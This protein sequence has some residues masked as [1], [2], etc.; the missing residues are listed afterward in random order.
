V[1]QHPGATNIPWIRQDEATLLVQRAERAAFVSDGRT[2]H[3][4]IHYIHHQ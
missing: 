2:L 1:L 4:R 3:V